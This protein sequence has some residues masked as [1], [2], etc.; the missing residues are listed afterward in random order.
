MDFEIAIITALC[1]YFLGSINFA[2][3]VSH[4]AMNIDIRDF[5][6]GNAGS[7]NAYRTLG[8]KL[9]LLVALGDLLKGGIAVL[10]GWW[11]LGPIGKL[12]AGVFVIIGHI[13][14]VFFGFRGGKGVA[15]TI[16]LMLV[17]DWRVFLIC[18]GAFAVCVLLT[19]Y[20]SLGS[21]L[22]AV[23]FPIGMGLFYNWD[24]LFVVPSILIGALIIF[25]HRNNIKRLIKGQESKFRFSKPKKVSDDDSAGNDKK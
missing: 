3:I 14:P 24:V 13:Y 10:V 18:F 5:G 15:T 23:L 7:T 12:I 17:I 9:A 20:V 8:G 4:K 19:R 25:G 1:A 21:L 22:I 2:I 11:L 16:S 6:S